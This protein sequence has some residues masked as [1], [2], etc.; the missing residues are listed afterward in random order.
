MRSRSRCLVHHSMMAPWQHNREPLPSHTPSEKNLISHVN[1]PAQKYHLTRL[2]TV[3]KGPKHPA[4]RVSRHLRPIR[5]LNP[6]RAIPYTH[7][8]MPSFLAASTSRTPI[9]S[10]RVHR[11]RL[12]AAETSKHNPGLPRSK[13]AWVSGAEPGP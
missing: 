9:Q 3:S 13:C 10:S 5:Y 8:N 7:I 4:P 2:I 11:D 1:L 6:R 12:H